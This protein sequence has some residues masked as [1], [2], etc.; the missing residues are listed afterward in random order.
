MIPKDI[1]F[2]GGYMPI[3]ERAISD[4]KVMYYP[5]YIRCVTVTLLHTRGSK[6]SDVC[7]Y[8]SCF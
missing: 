7:L 4:V 3:C 6:L 1:A 2:I 5:V 8:I